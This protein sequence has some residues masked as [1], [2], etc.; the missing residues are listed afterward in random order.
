MK[1]MMLAIGLIGLANI[2]IGQP[3]P[4]Y[5]LLNFLNKV[6]G[7]YSLSPC[8]ISN[9][10]TSVTC[11]P[12]TST[13]LYVDSKS[14]AKCTLSAEAPNCIQLFFYLAQFNQWYCSG[15]NFKSSTTAP[16]VCTLQ[17]TLIS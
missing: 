4:I 13:P 3:S 6:S 10:N 5:N 2:A 7:K 15:G 14:G 12:S 1:K 8:V 11:Q 17:P 16:L 9:N